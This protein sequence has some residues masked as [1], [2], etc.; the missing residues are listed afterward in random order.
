LV[1]LAIVAGCG[2][3]DRSSP[4]SSAS[5][6]GAT[7]LGSNYSDPAPKKALQDVLDAF[8]ASSGIDVR[9][10]TVD[11]KSFQDSISAYLQGRPEDVFSWF[12]GYR[13]RFFADQ[14][15]A[16]DVSGVWDRVGPRYPDAMRI[17]ATASDGKQ[18]LVPFV[19]YPWVVIYRK[20]VWAAKGY[21]PPA[22]FA[23][24]KT[25][26][27]RMQ[28]DGL[29]PMAFAD[30]DGWP[31]MGVFDILDMR[32]NGYDFHV[33]LA[34]GKER[35]TDPRVRRVFETW[36]E[37]LPYMQ[38]AALG[39]TW[40]D[41]ARSLIAGEAGMYFA[42]TFA[43]EQAD[44]GTRPDLDFFPFPALGTAFDAERAMDAP[45]NGF[46][47]SR[48]PS[49][50]V[51][52]RALVEYLASGPAQVRYVTANPSRIAAAADAD[53]SGYTDLQRKMATAIASAGRVA[54]FLD[55][56]S[57]PDFTGVNGMQAFLQEFLA[58]PSQDLDALL[59]RI[60]RFWDSLPA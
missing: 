39:R 43:A 41:A 32:L 46:M 57:R 22:T 18:Y 6:R 34:G 13:M 11:T 23:E 48:S 42:G 60:Q 26:L 14:G 59:T 54:Q 33:A 44:E 38:P 10:N 58:D 31:A 19:T 24:L 45:V 20:S 1:C 21:T 8:T 27:G 5:P 51:A 2:A 37:L 50:P 25:L 7:S 29:V 4:A 17:A 12:A 52:A 49:D 40:Q 3:V 28:A 35:W 15:L 47:I 53:T 36:R 55:R 30:K 56:D 9:V 16:S